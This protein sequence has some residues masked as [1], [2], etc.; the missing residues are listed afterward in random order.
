[1]F[2]ALNYTSDDATDLRWTALAM[3]PD[4]PIAGTPLEPSRRPPRWRTRGDGRQGGQSR[5]R[6]RFH[7]A[8]YD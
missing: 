3:Y 5:T 8:G 2:T 1:M 6:T 4:Q 7:S